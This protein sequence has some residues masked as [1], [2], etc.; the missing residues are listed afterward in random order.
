MLPG[1]FILMSLAAT[2]AAGLNAPLPSAD[3]AIANMMQRDSQRRSAL[4][5]YIGTR[6]YVFEN[7][8]RHKRAEMLVRVLCRRDGSKQFEILS[9]TGWGGA[10]KY[11]FNKLLAAEEEASRPGN[12]ED[13]RV[14]PENYAFESLRRDDIDGR[15]VYAIDITPRQRKKYLMRGTIWVDADEYAIVRMRGTA[16]KN[17]SFWIKSARFVRQYD[18]RGP[19]WVPVSNTSTTDIRIF[20]ST[21]LTIDYF[22]YVL[23]SSIVSTVGNPS[24]GRVP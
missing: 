19:F 12:P 5:G 3:D 13:T 10:R 4:D 16:A 17:P 6:R 22:D 9:S 20:G 18:K 11:V 1:V 2:N 21:D 15:P 8:K 23:K 14:T 7:I 24:H